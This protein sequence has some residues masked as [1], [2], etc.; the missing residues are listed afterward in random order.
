MNKT[1][2]KVYVLFHHPCTDGMGAK[3]AAWK[4]FGDKAEYL[5]VNYNNPM[6]RIEDGSEVY[7]IDF[8]YPK[9]EL[10][11]L[12]NR[13]SKLVVL[14]HHKT[15]QTD[16]EGEDYAFFDMNKSGAVLAWEYFFPNIEVPS[17]LQIIQDRDLWRWAFPATKHILNSLSI[18]GDKVETW[19]EIIDAPAWMEEQGRSISRFREKELNFHTKPENVRVCRILGYKVAITNASTLFSE[20]GNKMCSDWDVDF[21]ITY[22][23]NPQGLVEL[24]LRS[25]GDFD[26]SEVAKT[27]GGGGHKN[28][29]G[30]R[31]SLETLTWWLKD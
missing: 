29:S 5:G 16:L 28:A 9:E 31:I 27:L 30:A 7:I 19:D 24:S 4:K 12:K 8:S 14:D 1:K 20:I 10:R 13:S 6:P 25:I 23:V 26:V 17:L 3:Y 18:H 2:N 22:K 15:A 11:A 21:G